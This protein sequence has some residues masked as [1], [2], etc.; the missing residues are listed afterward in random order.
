MPECLLGLGS[1]LGER[2]AN[3]RAALDELRGHSALK[4][5]RHSSLM[6]SAPIGGPAEQRRYL[7]AAAVI[8]TSLAPHDL[9]AVL[10]GIEGKLG[11]IRSEPW[12]PR[13]I[14]LDI[15]LYGDQ[16]IESPAA[17]VPHPRFAERRFALAPAAEI[18]G[19][20]R[21][22]TSQKTINQLLA[23]LG[24][25][26]SRELGIQVIL[27]PEDVQRRTLAL[28]QAGQRIS[29]VP[30][31]GAL[32]AGHLSL[33]EIARKR[34]DI[35]IA[36][37]FVNPTQFGP[38]EDFTRYPRT[39]DADLDALSSA[40]CGIAL[41]PDAAAMYP[42]GFSTYVE[43]PAVS[44][45]L[46]GV[47]RP[48]HFRGVATIVL[49]LF[50]IIPAHVACFGQKDYQQLQVIRRM[51]LDLNLP[52]EIVACPTV[53]EPDGLAMSSRNRYLS[54]T[55]REQ[56]LSLSRA[57]GRAGELAAAGERDAMKIV[58]EMRRILADAKI[59]RIDYIA[60]ADPDTLAEKSHLDGPA[61]ALIAAHVGTTRLID[62]QLL[63]PGG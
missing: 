30:T 46:E 14:D 58:A 38:Q 4:L 42:S 8:E 18:A 2:V 15:L 25:S 23:D 43:P 63:Q 1:N 35:V 57:L 59:D 53:R 20:W 45:P 12:G 26:G 27:S 39:L 32:H 37:I 44:Q 61:I 56:A 36:T 29:L 52:I 7:N 13:T 3:L 62:N 48:G 5:L 6:E 47:C 24:P 31:M 17:I 49:K 51:A 60:I 55:E 40:G 34:S 21:H 33:V 11:R 16:T 22:P 10:L 28:R 9:M 41:V 19:D 50:N 54:P